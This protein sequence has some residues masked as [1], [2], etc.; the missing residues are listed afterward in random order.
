MK[1]I[2]LAETQK[3]SAAHF[4]SEAVAHSYL[5]EAADHS[6]RN[7]KCF[8]K[9]PNN[10]QHKEYVQKQLHKFFMVSAQNIH[11]LCENFHNLSMVMET[12]LMD[13]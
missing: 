9:Q 8:Q 12:S 5:S 2:S 4:L 6:L 11:T 7:T 1:K 3:I 10:L 13:G